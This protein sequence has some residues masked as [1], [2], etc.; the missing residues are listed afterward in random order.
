ML[1]LPSKPEI[2]TH[3]ER[4]QRAIDFIEDHLYDS[5]TID[6]IAS[7]AAYSVWHFQRVFSGMVGETVGS[8]VRRRRLGSALRDLT[9][10]NIPII[11][12]AWRHGFESQ[13]A[14][15]RAF[16]AM[17]G[18]TPGRCRSEG[19]C[20]VM[21]PSG[22]VMLTQEYLDRLYG[23]IRMEP[24]IRKMG[25]MNI[26]GCGAPFISIL[27]PEANSHQVIPGLWDTFLKRMGEIPTAAQGTLYGLCEP[28]PK[29]ERSHP[30]ECY[31]IAGAPVSSLDTM[32]EGMVGR[33]VHEAT[34]AVFTHVGKLDTLGRTM[35]YIYG[36]WI[37]NSN[38][39]LAAGP[40][41][42]V[43]DHRFDPASDTSELDICIPVREK[44][45]GVGGE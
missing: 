10:T 11:E 24:V 3:L 36:S 23:G 5:I 2:M 35:G 14:F 12:I 30:E 39:E 38:Y 28:V 41:L 16:K 25:E 43:Y 20:P 18:C 37:P 8:Y 31:Y 27:S 33:T 4:I 44:G 6:E 40:D 17:F 9:A 19:R 32:P 13:E 15:T 21:R 45:E 7:T 34:Y 1:D 29:D 26:V 22:R 42:E